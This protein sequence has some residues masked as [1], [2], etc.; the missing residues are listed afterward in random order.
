MRN[1]FEN[2]VGGTGT[3]KDALAIAEELEKEEKTLSQNANNNANNTDNTANSTDSKGGKNEGKKEE[4]TKTSKKPKGGKGKGSENP[5][6]PKVVLNTNEVKKEEEKNTTPEQKPSSPKDEPKADNNEDKKTSSADTKP[7]EEEQKP[8]TDS[9][10]ATQEEASTEIEE[11]AD[12]TSPTEEVKAKPQKVYSKEKK[13]KAAE[14]T[15]F[16]KITVKIKPK[17]MVRVVSLLMLSG[18]ILLTIASFA[19]KTPIMDRANARGFLGKLLNLD[20]VVSNKS[21]KISPE[22]LSLDTLM[23][24]FNSNLSENFSPEDFLGSMG[25]AKGKGQVVEPVQAHYEYLLKKSLNENKPANYYELLESYDRLLDSN[26]LYKELKG[27]KEVFSFHKIIVEVDSEDVPTYVLDGEIVPLNAV[28]LGI[29]VKVEP[30]EI[31]VLNGKR[32]EIKTAIE[33]SLHSKKSKDLLDRDLIRE[34]V[35]FAVKRI[36]GVEAKEVYRFILVQPVQPIPQ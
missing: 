26:D 35:N 31:S 36:T 22:G 8:S 15:D 5:K 30:D 34:T 3:G 18:M 9:N 10:E 6:Q 19:F 21:D 32:E 17:K 20:F 4:K 1:K 13:E 16:S 24:F 11:K 29:A 28:A 23:E 2:L 12:D 14:P 7:V 27:Q 25:S 33:F